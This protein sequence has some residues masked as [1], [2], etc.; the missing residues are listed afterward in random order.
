MSEGRSPT[1]PLAVVPARIGP[2]DW[3]VPETA[4]R[5]QRTGIGHTL[6]LKIV[7]DPK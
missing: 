5:W 6:N 7:S 3:A 1:A 2:T 4:A